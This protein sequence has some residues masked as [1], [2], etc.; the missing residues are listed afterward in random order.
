MFFL[1]AAE[2]LG[3]N[4]AYPCGEGIGTRAVKGAGSINRS[5]RL[6]SCVEIFMEEYV[7]VGLNLGAENEVTSLQEAVTSC[8]STKEGVPP[9]RNREVRLAEG[10]VATSLL[11]IPS[12]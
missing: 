10:P 11:P 12:L 1:V 5:C 4:D 7:S 8:L 9:G 6:F 3:V 2:K